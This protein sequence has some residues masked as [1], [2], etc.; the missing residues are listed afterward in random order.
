[1]VKGDP[2]L[3]AA[4]EFK[5]KTAA[6]PFVDKTGQLK[7]G[8][9]ATPPDATMLANLVA[10]LDALLPTF[11]PAATG[12]KA[13]VVDAHKASRT[14][15]ADFAQSTAMAEPRCLA[16]D[17]A[18]KAAKDAVGRA[19][20]A[21]GLGLKSAVSEIAASKKQVRAATDA[22][23]LTQGLERLENAIKAAERLKQFPGGDAPHSRAKLGDIDKRWTGA[24][25]ALRKDLG[26]V[27]Q[28]ITAADNLPA[29]SKAA[30]GGMVDTALARFDG[31]A[32]TPI[33]VAMTT[34]PSNENVAER[35]KAREQGLRLVR[36][37]RDAISGDPVISSLVIS[38]AFPTD[39]FTLA[40]QALND[41][42]LNL[43]RAV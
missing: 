4:P 25:A 29:E 27:K 40:H 37:F 2:D 5:S 34:K 39:S 33:I 28:E 22:A 3:Q 13:A 42:D 12:Y 15:A 7:R 18:L 31:A 24:V 20:P 30:I 36:Q 26:A 11:D 17:A 1:M 19:D 43:S 32:F 41:L 6:G 9:E 21:D 14:Q 10:E 8:L 38:R 16:A 23:A 35:M